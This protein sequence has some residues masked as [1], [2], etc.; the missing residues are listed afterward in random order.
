MAVALP[1]LDTASLALVPFAFPLAAFAF[2]SA[3][4]PFVSES[5]CS[6]LSSDSCSAA[7]L[8]FLDLDPT[9]FCFLFAAACCD[10]DRTGAASVS[11]SRSESADA[12]A[13]SESAAA[14]AA[15]AFSPALD[16]VAFAL[17]AAALEPLSAPPSALFKSDSDGCAD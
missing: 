14:V 3:A 12:S 15:L 4:A 10:L 5:D 16:F 13:R 9:A 6:D 17:V 8:G 7:N 1:D 11:T 2:A